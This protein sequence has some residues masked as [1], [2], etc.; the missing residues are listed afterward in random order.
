MELLEETKK[1]KELTNDNHACNKNKFEF[2]QDAN[3][4]FNGSR[5]LGKKIQILIMKIPS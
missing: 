3:N 4:S 1:N 5:K 2:E